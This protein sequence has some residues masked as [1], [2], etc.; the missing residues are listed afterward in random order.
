MKRKR[1]SSF[2]V[3]I[4]YLICFFA[5]VV[6]YGGKKAKAGVDDEG[7]ITRM[8]SKITTLNLKGY[9][10]AN[11]KNN[12]KYWQVQAYENNLGIIEQIARANSS[13]GVNL[14]RILGT[15]YYGVDAYYDIDVVEYGKGKALGWTLKN[16][17]DSFKDRD[18]IFSGDSSAVTDWSDAKLLIFDVDA[19]AVSAQTE[20]RIAFEENRIGRETY[21]LVAGKT[22]WLYSGGDYTETLVADG[23]YVPL[24]NGFSG[25]VLLPLD[26]NAFQ[27]YYNDGGNGKMDLNSVQ[28]IILS[29]KGNSL[30]VGK[31]VYIDNFALGGEFGNPCFSLNGVD[32]S[33]KTV[34]DMENLEKRDNYEYSSLQWYGEFVGKLLTG[35]AY[36]YKA[37]PNE[38]LKKSAENIIEKLALAQGEDGYLGVYRGG[39]RF[40]VNAENWDLWN[41]YHCVVG[42]FEW[43]KITG[44]EKAYDIA[45]KAL[46]C[47]LNA[48]KDK[49]Y[50][51]KGGFETNRAIAHGFAIAYQVTGA[52][53]YLTEAERIIKNDCQDENG[54]YKSALSGRHFYNSSS[55][56]WEVLHIIMTLGILYEET[57]NKEYYDVMSTVWEDV[58]NSDVHNSGGF[59]TNEGA[60]GDPYVDGVIET[61]CTVAWTAFSNEYYKYNK[62]VTV[63]DELER[64]YYNAMLG[65][66][67]D[68]DKY[69]SYNTPMDGYQGGGGYYDG[70]RV[71]SQQDISFQYIAT[72]PDF[73][74]CQANLARG[75]GQISEWACVTDKNALYLNYYGKCEI[76]TSINGKEVI[77]KETTDYPVNGKID[78]EIKGLN[79]E[80][81]FT[82]YLRIPS[83]AKASNVSFDGNSFVAKEGEYFKITKQWKN[84]DK[85]KLNLTTDFHYWIGLNS[86]YHK[87]SVYYGPILFTA[88]EYYSGCTT[89]SVNVKSFENA[90]IES[91]VTEGAMLFATVTCENGAKVRL[92]DFASAGKYNGNSQPSAYSSWLYVSSAPYYSENAHKQWINSDK[93]YIYS[94]EDVFDKKGYYVGDKVEIKSSNR[95]VEVSGVDVFEENGSLFFLMPENDVEIAIIYENEVVPPEKDD[96]TSGKHNKKTAIACGVAC[97]CGVVGAI[98]VSLRIV[99]IKGKKQNE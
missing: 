33:K 10:G 46:D 9:V 28:K 78:I 32:Y 2:L 6:P 45:V 83:W 42:L 60:V 27:R 55:N 56:R 43:Y 82:L 67:L 65:A 85:I 59:T 86:K 13:S 91:G 7:E 30:S 98:V 24:P 75:L 96:K 99:K 52:K 39:E 8:E 63:A 4:M 88:D 49:S 41:H 92:V 35:T 40:S 14:N 53:K 47:I 77:V 62:S 48:F 94:P 22:V 74:C 87:T 79:G 50:L 72:S 97:G 90:I 81:E 57:G 95:I 89:A 80:E 16:V 21:E 5:L 66:L 44:N 36:C 38:Q 34:W 31:T 15:D 1:V 58:Y 70:R 64:S 84:G 68:D 3:L 19:S 61:C 18:F 93:Y 37:E 71:T 73:N 25:T 11:L 20:I 23:G 12:I 69:C 26:E 76:K 29:L 54:W 51:V 17:P